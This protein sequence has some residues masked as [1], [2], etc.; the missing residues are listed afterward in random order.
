MELNERILEAAILNEL[1]R[2]KVPVTVTLLNGT[3]YQGVVARF[4][5][6][7][8]VLLIDGIQK[9][10]YKHSVASITPQSTLKSAQP[11]S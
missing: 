4:D 10:I 8:I 2:D 3:E 5:V 1:A 11:K 7:V 6:L 9:I